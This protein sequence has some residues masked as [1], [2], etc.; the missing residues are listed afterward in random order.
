LI[1]LWLIAGPGGARMDFV[2]GWL[3]QLPDFVQS[4]WS[5]DLITGQSIGFMQHTKALDQ[6]SSIDT[7]L[8]DHHI[9]LSN[10][11]NV[12][13]AGS[14]HGHYLESLHDEISQ[15]KIRVFYIDLSGA[16]LAQVCWEFA[17]KTFLTK[18]RSTGCEPW[19]AID[20]RIQIENITDHDRIKK[21]QEILKNY[22]CD[23][24]CP[25]VSHTS[26]MYTELF[27]SGGSYYLCDRANIT[28]DSL[29]HRNWDQMLERSRTP[30]ELTV[31]GH[32]WKKHDFY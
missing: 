23:S 29:Y 25:T 1:K 15:Q 14:M 18:N 3:G 17:V 7:F 10:C 11:A 12:V 27:Q 2:A 22:N 24:Q 31:W 8:S 21:F 26:L 6:G 28:C 16:D 5:V 20:S 4:N 13:Y 9:Q 30:D 32:H 19:S